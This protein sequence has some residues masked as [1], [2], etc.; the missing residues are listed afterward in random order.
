MHDSK[1]L[2]ID[3]CFEKRSSTLG[4]SVIK[5]KTAPLYFGDAKLS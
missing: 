3:L 4:L 2:G 5:L 1:K